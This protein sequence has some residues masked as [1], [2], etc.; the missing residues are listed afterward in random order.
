MPRRT[1]AGSP[2][3]RRRARGNRRCRREPG[4]SSP[5]AG[6]WARSQPDTT[7]GR[8]TQAAR[9]VAWTAPP[10]GQR[11]A[12]P[13]GES[14]LLEDGW[15][16]KDQARAAG[17]HDRLADGF[18]QAGPLFGGGGPPGQAPLASE[19]RD[20]PLQREVPPTDRRSLAPE[21]ESEPPGLQARGPLLEE[22]EAGGLKEHAVHADPLAWL[23]REMGARLDRQRCDP[24]RLQ[25]H[26]RPVRGS[27]EPAFEFLPAPERGQILRRFAVAL[28][29]SIAGREQA[30]LAEGVHGRLFRV[31]AMGHV[32]LE[33]RGAFRRAK[34]GLVPRRGGEPLQDL[35]TFRLHLRQERAANDHFFQQL[36]QRV[37][38]QSEGAVLAPHPGPHGSRQHGGVGKAHREEVAADR[39]GTA[40][41]GDQRI[42]G[43][44][45]PD[46]HGCPPGGVGSA[47]SQA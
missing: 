2:P 33:D 22:A 24:Q 1:S 4:A 10:R 29:P 45:Q 46:A 39:G 14:T 28:S 31:E 44:D 43:L 6:L 21:G 18:R 26:R 20:L 38:S 27:G 47:S 41:P 11:L 3:V 25:I 19:R 17:G 42:E 30:F 40:V 35:I 15:G 23:H 7:E 12:V 36:P 8:P 34:D 32:A 37:P 16:E 5:W 13:A 9:T